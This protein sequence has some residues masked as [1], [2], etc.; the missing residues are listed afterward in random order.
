MN[1]TANILGLI[2]ARGGS[3]AVVNKNIRTIAGLPLLAHSIYAAANSG[4]ISRTVVSTDCEAIAQVARAHGAEVPF[5]RPAEFSTDTALAVDVMR[6]ALS[7]LD[8]QG[9]RTDIVVYLQPTSPLRTARHIEEALNAFRGSNADALVSV[10]E[11]PHRFT[12]GCLLQLKE[13]CVVPADPKM[14]SPLMRQAKETFFARNGPAIYVGKAEFLRTAESLYS[15]K[16]AAYVMSAEDSLDIDTEWELSVA[17]LL[18]ERRA[19]EARRH[20]EA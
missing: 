15:G 14:V 12:P 17:E 20:D 2:P 19:K 9:W 5:L 16:T 6:H 3:K 18:L 13:K 11:V 1:A 4:V 7:A 10:M 8:A